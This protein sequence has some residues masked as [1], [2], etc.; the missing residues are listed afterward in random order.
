MCASTSTLVNRAPLLHIRHVRGE[1][2]LS[3]YVLTG[4]R[5]LGPTNSIG[6]ETT[7]TV[8]STTR[9]SKLL[10]TSSI[11]VRPASNGAN[12]KL[13]SITT[14][15]NCGIVVI[16]PSAVSRRQHVVVGTCNTRLIL[17]SNGLNVTNTV[18]GTSR[19]T[20]RVP[21]DFITKR[22]AGP[23]GTETRFRAAKP[24]V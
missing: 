23:R 15:H 16:V 18:T 17:A 12:V 22:F 19:L 7:E 13:Y 20:T 6:S 5:C 24:R 8:V 9:H 11:V 21:R 14:I 1:L 2:K 4:L 3:T 10:Y